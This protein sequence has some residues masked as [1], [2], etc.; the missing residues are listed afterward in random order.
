MMNTREKAKENLKRLDISLRDA[1]IMMNE[2]RSAF[3]HTDERPN[4][5]ATKKFLKKLEEREV[6]PEIWIDDLCNKAM[7]LLSACDLDVKEDS[8]VK[9]DIKFLKNLFYVDNMELLKIYM[10]RDEIEINWEDENPN[11]QS[12]LD[13]ENYVE[14]V[15]AEQKNGDELLSKVK[16]F[17]KDMRNLAQISE[18]MLFTL[19]AQLIAEE[20]VYI[21]ILEKIL[22][23]N[24]P[25]KLLL[26]D[27]ELRKGPKEVRAYYDNP[28]SRENRK[29]LQKLL[30]ERKL[31]LERMLKQQKEEL[32]EKEK[33]GK[34]ENI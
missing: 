27:K 19:M 29:K 25:V 13:L 4:S 28:L 21:F 7:E 11:V 2:T 9:K 32:E 23:D 26:T 16:A 6:N 10:E 1:S 12:L 5:A 24:I 20:K 14:E 34:G 33:R 22:N 30:V 31:A 8:E 17:E 3:C 18:K 15:A